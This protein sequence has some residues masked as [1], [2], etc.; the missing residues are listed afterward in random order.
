[1]TGY[2][3]ARLGLQ[4]RDAN[5]P[6]LEGHRFDAETVRLMGIAFDASPAAPVLVR[7]RVRP[8]ALPG[9]NNLT[10]SVLVSGSH[11]DHRNDGHLKFILPHGPCSILEQ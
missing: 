6:Y 1:M 7:R 5:Q 2:I 10:R 4:R 8:C 11:A 3:G 9:G